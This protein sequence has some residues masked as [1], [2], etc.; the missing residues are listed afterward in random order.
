M[1]TPLA[2]GVYALENRSL[3]APSPKVDLVLATVGEP[4]DA[5]TTA[6]SFRLVLADHRIP[7]EDERPDGWELRP[8]GRVRDSL[9]VPGGGRT[10][11]RARRLRFSWR[12]GPRASPPSRT[13]TSLWDRALSR[14]G[15]GL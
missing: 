3:G 1:A 6:A 15:V 5:V 9:V 8:P 4:G 13:P 14:A 2:P 12:T 7:P 10:T 11:T